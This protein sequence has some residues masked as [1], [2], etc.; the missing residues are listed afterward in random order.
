MQSL[1][2]NP[3]FLSISQFWED[4]GVDA[5]ERYLAQLVRAAAP[6]E[7]PVREMGAKTAG[8]PAAPLAQKALVP[9]SDVDAN[10]LAALAADAPDIAALERLVVSDAPF[11][12]DGK[13][14]ERMLGSFA[15]AN[16]VLVVN[17]CPQAEDFEAGQP[18]A[19][20]VGR[21]FDAMLAA[22]GLSRQVQVSVV[23][24]VF[25]KVANRARPRPEDLVQCRPFLSR[26]LALQQPKV[27]ITL[28][29]LAMITL[30]GKG[31][32][33]RKRAGVLQDIR[34]GDWS[35]PGISLIHPQHHLVTPATK[36]DAWQHL[37]ALRRTLDA[38][39]VERNTYP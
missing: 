8:S 6:P 22:I 17:D 28:G 10:A 18:L 14:V 11:Q 30:C 32:P 15:P 34:F 27:V 2:D 1:K 19:G 4:A 3:D 39:G 13:H 24:L 23:N 36:R 16:D 35:G 5:D 29:N 37:K 31:D 7:P 21:L 9:A 33:I 12:L 26:A 20:G 25:W 38:R